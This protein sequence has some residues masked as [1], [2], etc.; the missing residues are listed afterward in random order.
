MIEKVNKV[1]D[2]VGVIGSSPTNPTDPEALK[3]KRFRAF[4]C[5]NILGES[6]AKMGECLPNVYREAKYQKSLRVCKGFFPRLPGFY[7]FPDR[8]GEG[9][10]KATQNRI[11][12]RTPGDVR[13][14]PSFWT[15]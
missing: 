2:I 6:G 1:V 15:P 14:L 13:V 11:R 4:F 8:P 3:I 7:F 9:A 5:L 10:L 12:Q